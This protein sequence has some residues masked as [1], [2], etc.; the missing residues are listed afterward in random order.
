MADTANAIGAGRDLEYPDTQFLAILER[1]SD[2]ENLLQILE[3]G[4]MPKWSTFWRRC[5]GPNASDELRAAYA[6]AHVANAAHGL[7][8]VP[9]IAD[10]FHAAEER[11]ETDGPKGRTT[12]VK[13]VD[14]LGHRNLRV[15]V[16]QWQAERVIARMASKT[17]LQNPDGSP[18]AVPV[19]NMTVLPPGE[20][21]PAVPAK[22][23]R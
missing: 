8:Q 6:D 18:L 15:N 13:H 7:A 21:A 20:A 23:E 10:N 4:G 1:W 22:G 9:H 17:A 14:A 16:R 19:I 2:G 12:S 11:T 3:E 5:C